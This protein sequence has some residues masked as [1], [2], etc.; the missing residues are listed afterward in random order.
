MVA[1][2]PSRASANSVFGSGGLGEPVLEENARL[3]AL[4]GAGAAEH[5]A[6]EF[7]L[8]N[9]ASIAEA[10]HLVLEA[11]LLAAR[12]SVSTLHYGDEIGTESTFPSV[13]LVVRLPGAWILS[14]SYLHGTNGQFGLV[15]PETTGT[16]SIIEADGRG[17]ITYAR[18]T[19]GKR[20][21]SLRAGVD[22]DVIG[23]SYHEEWARDFADP[24]LETARDTIDVTWDRLGRWR[25]GA[26][27]VRPRWAIG[28]VYETERRLSLTLRER[29]GASDLRTTD[30]P[31]VIPAG[32]AAGFQISPT[33]RLRLVG[34]YRRQDWNEESL[35]SDLVSFRPLVRYSVGLERVGNLGSRS[36]L[37]RLPFRIGG[38]FLNW[39]DLLPPAGALDI[40]GGSAKIDEWAVSIGSGLRTKDGGGAIDFSLEG[41]QRGKKEELGAT[42]TFFRLGLSLRVSDETWR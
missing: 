2:A 8:V 36:I 35:T 31:L 20:L 4:G 33:S 41:G 17:G 12:R 19:L 1:F 6:S 23:G 29:T 39:P 40:T 27:I 3:R 26:Q 25:F 5:G 37:G 15:R 21:G 30:I 18:A 42:E 14:G 11:T 32:F 34:Q 7:S 16:A 10:Q 38:T 22:F 24:A 28:G 9:P 13:R